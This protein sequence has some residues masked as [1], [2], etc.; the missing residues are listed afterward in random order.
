MSYELFLE[1]EVHA[2]R[3]DLPGVIRQRIR[4]QIDALGLDPRPA[5]SQPLDISGL[6]LPESIELRRVRLERR[7]IVYAINEAER[8]VWVLAVRRRPPYNYDD[9]AALLER[10]PEE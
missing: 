7:R 5:S 4:R 9:L 2:Q 8:W 6:A 10:L 1:P 3:R